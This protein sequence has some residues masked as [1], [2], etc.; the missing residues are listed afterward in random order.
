MQQ[1]NPLANVRFDQTT[2][3]VCEKCGSNLFTEGLYLR[4][5]SKFLVATNSDKDQVIPVPTFFCVKCKHVNKEFSPLGMEEETKGGDEE[6]DN[7]N[8]IF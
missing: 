2:G 5:V 4:K 7:Y 1:Q 3:V 6:M 8:P